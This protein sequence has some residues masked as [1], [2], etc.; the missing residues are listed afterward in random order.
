M[1]Y[2]LKD[3]QIDSSERIID[4][5][6]I[7]STGAVNSNTRGLIFEDENIIS[8]SFGHSPCHTATLE[9][10]KTMFQTGDQITMCFEGP[11]VKL[12]WDS[13]DNHHLSTTNK[14][15]CRNSYWGNKDEKFGK[16]FYEN[17]GQRFIDHCTNHQQTHHFMIMTPTLITTIDFDLQDNDCVIVY[18]GA[19]SRDFHYDNVPCDVDSFVKLFV[20]QRNFIEIPDKKTIAGRIMYPYALSVN[21]SPENYADTVDSMLN[22]G[23]FT[24][25]LRPLTMDEKYRGVDMKVIQSYTGAPVIV[26]SINFIR[27]LVPLS[28]GKKCEILGNSPN[29]KLLV[30]RLMDACR[31][32]KDMV[33]E[34]FE[35][36][37]FLFVPTWEFIEGLESSKT[38][39]L[40][41]LNK[42]R[43]LG[44]V[45]FMDAKSPLGNTAREYNLL[46]VLFL[47]L[48]E[49]KI[50]EGILAYKQ[51]TNS[52]KI[53]KLFILR[54]LKMIRQGKFDD[55]FEDRRA[56]DRLLDIC[57][58]SDEYARKN[59]KQRDY[60]EVLEFSLNGLIN[61]ERGA[62]LYKID[63]AITKFNQV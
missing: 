48:P 14:I 42:Y 37:D 13:E 33:L 31:P 35:N 34:Y 24:D 7:A 17:G 58:L 23:K 54:N 60:K 45:G 5:K 28:Y 30:F 61:N 6:F 15:D 29:I 55:T 10:L 4:G 44:T 40:D 53:L 38:P 11:L 19:V 2:T 12:W 49:S 52:K 25:A 26:R 21:H 1:S 51:Y 43:E 36:Y 50:V 32:K 20:E 63:K 59:C 41:I 16:L 3:A 46:M 57:A 39:K 56:T 18:L 62:S 8:A 27:K 22:R 47:C 9:D